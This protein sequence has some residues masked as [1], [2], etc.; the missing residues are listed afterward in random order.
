MVGQTFAMY[1]LPF[2]CPEAFV[3]RS[4]HSVLPENEV[5]KTLNIDPFLLLCYSDD[6]CGVNLLGYHL[7]RVSHTFI[8]DKLIVRT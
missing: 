6:Q 1:Y 8:D 4:M 5:C 7:P 3:E 2:Y